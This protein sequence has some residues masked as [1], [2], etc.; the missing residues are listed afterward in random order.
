MFLYYFLNTE[1][2]SYI[3]PRGFFG[4]SPLAIFSSAGGR[5]KSV[6]KQIVKRL[7]DGHLGVRLQNQ[8]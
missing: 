2:I 4:L 8:I 5:L 3:V 6:Y 1:L 7:V